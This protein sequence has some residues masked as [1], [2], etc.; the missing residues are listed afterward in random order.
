MSVPAKCPICGLRFETNVIDV[1]GGQFI[2]TDNITNCPR[3][4]AVASIEDGTYE[5][6]LAGRVISAIRSQGAVRSDVIALQ[7][8][9]ESVQAGRVSNDEATKIAGEIGPLFG[10]LWAAAIKMID[11]YFS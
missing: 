1:Q 11:Q 3:C 6:D 7:A 9:A 4:G 10:A 5:F 2:I 8:L